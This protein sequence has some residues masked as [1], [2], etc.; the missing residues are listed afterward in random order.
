MIH[1][2]EQPIHERQI[3]GG[4]STCCGNGEGSPVKVV[5]R[6]SMSLGRRVQ[7]APRTARNLSQ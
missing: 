7:S 5:I 1:P 2:R 3:N 4:L 6:A